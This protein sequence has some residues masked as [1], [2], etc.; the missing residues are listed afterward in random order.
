MIW[1]LRLI[2]GLSFFGI[3]GTSGLQRI[4]CGVV[5]AAALGCMTWLRVLGKE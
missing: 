5:S 4:A 1:Y 2:A 3:F